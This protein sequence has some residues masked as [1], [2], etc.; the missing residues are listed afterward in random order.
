MELPYFEGGL[1]SKSS[2]LQNNNPPNEMAALPFLRLP[3]TS[4]E[5]Y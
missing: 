4:M 1:I 3:R 2:I 5:F